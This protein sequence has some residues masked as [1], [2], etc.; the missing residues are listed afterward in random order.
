MKR[1]EFD[2]KLKEKSDLKTNKEFAKISSKESR[3]EKRKEEKKKKDES[4]TIP[5]KKRRRKKKKRGI[6][7]P[8]VGRRFHC[9]S[10]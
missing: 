2:E 5:P 8:K 7:N 10:R 9:S 1:K 4:M 3:R 6:E